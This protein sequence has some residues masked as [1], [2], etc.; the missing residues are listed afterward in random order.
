MAPVAGAQRHAADPVIMADAAPE[1]FAF[2]RERLDVARRAGDLSSVGGNLAPALEPLRFDA[3][4]GQR[5]AADEIIDITDAG[6]GATRVIAGFMGLTGPSAVLPEHYTE[7]VVNERRERNMSLS[8]FLDMFNH[9]AISHFWCAWAKYRLPV[10]FDS[11][12]GHLHDSFSRALAAL[13]GLGA[14]GEAIPDE[15]WLSMAGI[16]SRRVRSAGALERLVSGLF[17][18][19]VNIVEFEGRWVDLAENDRTRLGGDDGGAYATLGTDAVAGAA[20]YSVGSRFRVRVGPLDLAGF[21]RFFSADGLH[22]AMVDA[23][24]RTIGGNV[25]FAI[26]LVL[27]REAVPQLRLDDP[28]FPAALGQST[29]LLAGEAERD[30]DDAVLASR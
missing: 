24:R 2:V 4:V 22:A 16:M 21:R 8:D 13:A 11:D 14:G 27:Q 23:I 9:R 28:D 19:P 26:Q 10:A 18:L 20:V 15:A 1:F 3:A 7:R 30:R 12:G 25:D 5:F 29:W 6:E 17:G